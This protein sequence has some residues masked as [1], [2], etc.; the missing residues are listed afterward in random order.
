MTTQKETRTSAIR[1]TGAGPS[2]T[3]KECRSTS[4]SIGAHHEPRLSA[5]EIADAMPLFVVI[6]KSQT[7]RISRRCYLSLHAAEKAA[8]RARARGS[9]VTLELRAVVRVDGVSADV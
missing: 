2:T 7:E 5:N 8:K 1:E 3:Y 9:A 4:D 6:T